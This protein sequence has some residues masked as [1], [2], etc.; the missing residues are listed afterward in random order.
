MAILL[1]F[2]KLV[3]E[4]EN[5]HVFKRFFLLSAVMASFIIPGIVFV[6]YVE[7]TISQ[8]ISTTSDASLVSPQIAQRPSDMDVINWARLLWTIYFIGVVGFGF[9]FT[10]HLIQ[11][12]KRISINPKLKEHFSIKVLLKEKL[13]PHTFFNYI[14]LNKNKFESNAIPETVLIHEETHARQ[15]HSL[16]VLIIE[17]LQVIFWFNPLIYLFKKSIKLNHE[18]LADSAVLKKEKGTSNYQNILLSYLSQESLDNYQSPGIANAINYSSIK[19][20]FTVMKKRTSKKSI[21][22]RSFLLLPLLALLLLG[23]SERKFIEM[24]RNTPVFNEV[25]ILIEN[26]EIR[27][28]K[29]GELFFQEGEMIAVEELGDRL[30]KL[31][32]SLSKTE[33][34]QQIKAVIKVEADTPKKIIKDVDRILME[35]G[36]AQINV[37][38]PEP[39]YT[40]ILIETVTE[41]SQIKKYNGLAKKYNA[42]PI[43]KRIIPIADLKVLESIYKQ[44]TTAQKRE[45][46]PFPECLPKNQQDGASRNQMAEYNKLAKYYNDMPKD[47]MKILK[48]DVERLEYI[49]SLMSDK[50]KAD[51]EPFPNF[52]PPPPAPKAPEP[53]K[54]VSDTDYAANQIET[55]IE[56]QDPYDVVS[57]NIGVTQPKQPEPLLPPTYINE[58][59][60]NLPPTPPTPLSPI[61]SIEKWTKEGAD[62]M[63][64]GKPISAKKA[65]EVVKTNNKINIDLRE[66]NGE[67][68]LVKLS[69]HP[70]YI[71]N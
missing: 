21:V 65:L 17:F 3:L 62:F 37:I 38:G 70:I 5:M 31:N 30:L 71:K 18:F 15:Y 6:E 32:Q 64:N 22:L 12:L 59:T 20:R 28:N 48:A 36:V 25:G 58:T 50:Q 4:R 40:G 44:M 66:S 56:K 29:E 7:P 53:P 26:I 23:F 63:L 51:A 39:M 67:K 11:I 42:I 1:L 27:I 61:E 68:P 55:I 69:V 16:D 33:R 52:P 45:A 57:G 8:A 14:F 9:R 34:E 35:Y 10:K 49:Y 43:E 2:Y 41:Q 24:Q 54:N 60:P 47:K 46:L 19:K 13:P